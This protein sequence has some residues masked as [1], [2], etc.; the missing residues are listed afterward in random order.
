ML[1]DKVPEKNNLTGIFIGIALLL[2]SSPEIQE[3]FFGCCDLMT[4]G[5]GP[6]CGTRCWGRVGD[7]STPGEA[8][9]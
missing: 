1:N 3:I 5:N 9:T 4:V 7:S 6:G 8:S 2:Q